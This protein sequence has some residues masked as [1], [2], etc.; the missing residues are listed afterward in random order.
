MEVGQ[1]PNWGCSAKGIYI[2]TTLYN[3]E[4]TEEF[5]E[6]AATANLCNP[7]WR[8]NRA[9]LAS[10]AERFSDSY[11]LLSLYDV[12]LKVSMAVNVTGLW[13]GAVWQTGISV[14]ENILFPSLQTQHYSI[15]HTQI[16][17]VNNSNLITWSV[18]LPPLIRHHILHQ[19]GWR[20]GNADMNSGEV[21]GFESRPGHRLTWLMFLL[22]SLSQPR[23]TCG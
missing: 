17:L 23:H 15:N 2:Y 3:I 6:I 4:T 16:L 14:S 18:T 9:S 12:S 22:I 10:A 20:S 7:S 5:I 11:H 21:H 8:D 1:G 13:Y 19:E